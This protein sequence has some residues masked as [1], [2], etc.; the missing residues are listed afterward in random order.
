MKKTLSLLL[1]FVATVAAG[2]TKRP[3]IMP[4]RGHVDVEQLNR[5][6]DPK[7]DI[8]QLSVAELR[9]LRNAPAARRG[10]PFREAFLRG[11]YM[12]TSWYDSLQWAF[13]EH[14]TFKDDENS[15]LSYDEQYYEAALRSLRFTPAEQAFIHRVKQREDELLRHNFEGRR[16]VM[17]NV[18]N[19]MQLVDFDPQLR[20]QLGRNG[21]AIVPAGHNQLFHV[22]EKNDYSNFP[23]FVTTDLYLQL[24]HLYFDCMLRDVE[25]HRLDSVLRLF[26]DEGRRQAVAAR[27]SY[28]ADYF[29]VACGLLTGQYEKGGAVAD[30]IGKIERSTD[31]FSDF[32][33]YR[34]VQF[35]YSLFRPRGHYTRN[36]TLSR[37]FRAMMWL[38]TVPFATDKPRQLAEAVRLARLVG[39]NARLR[40]LYVQLTEPMAY[41][42]GQPD[43]VTIMQVYELVKG[44]D[45]R[46]LL[47]KKRELRRLR[48]AIEQLSE[49]QTRLRPKFAL[50]CRHKINL[51]PQRYLPDAEVL[52]EM[53]DYESQA[54]RRDVPSGLDVM[55]AMKGSQK[56]ATLDET[57]ENARWPHY[58]ET[59]DSMRRRMAQIDW[60]TTIAN[61]WLKALTLLTDTCKG[62]PYFMLTP[63]W[64]K[65]SLNAALSSWA[66]LKHDALLYSKQPFGAEC[67]GAGPPDPILR[68][69]VEPNV[70]FWRAAIRLLDATANVL[71]RHTLL[72]EKT[73]QN[74][75]RMREEAEFLLRMSEKELAGQLLSDMEYHQ[76]KHIGATFENISLD[77]LREPDQWLFSWDDVTG[78]DRKV[79]LVADVYTANAE[80]NPM[81][82][83][84]YGAVGLAD[85]LY[86]VVEL[87]GYLYLMRGAVL[88]YRELKEPLGSR[89]LTDEEWQQRLEQHPEEGRPQWMRDII[90]PLKKTPET[91]D[92]FFYSTGC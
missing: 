68:S 29:S 36:D 90:V 58:S 30:E 47:G 54:T 46:R 6:V 80:N 37:Y 52:Q 73:A 61:R 65:K 87:G 48:Q 71:R 81:K 21:F 57:A 32:L 1:L 4:G 74:T 88:S 20:R 15:A 51:M 63:E 7:M 72:T 35:A 42:F 91:N 19:A 43:N 62:Q 86:V 28:L 50:T 79:A 60:D 82:S 24:F 8:S 23:N 2:Q 92:R 22:Y 3:V 27:S 84:L 17:D 59:L 45:L 83:V 78:T 16:P 39:D 76:L 26:C 89:R 33:D 31:D 77:L 9:V 13:D 53:V 38:Q 70:A 14:F 41:L 40:Q 85:E 12:N 11:V 55:A 18:L 66:E 67:G 10:Y 64:E 44:H 49:H 56:L 5:P 69:Y 75:A 25:R 34:D